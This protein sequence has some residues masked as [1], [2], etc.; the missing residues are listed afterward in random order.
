MKLKLIPITTHKEAM[1]KYLVHTFCN[2][3]FEEFK[4]LYPKIG[5][6][7]PWIGYFALVDDEV[8]GV[9]GFKGPPTNGTVEIG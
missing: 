5:F 4:K 7:L 9:G 6:N 2:E 8:V 3:V 1:E